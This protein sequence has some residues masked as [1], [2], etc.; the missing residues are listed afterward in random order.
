MITESNSWLYGDLSKR[1]KSYINLYIL[2]YVKHAH[3][4][5]FCSSGTTVTK[6][7][8]NH[9]WRIKFYSACF[10]TPLYLKYI[11]QFVLPCS[12]L[13]GTGGQVS[14]RGTSVPN[15]AH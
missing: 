10:C 14:L 3:I 13:A 12:V 7:A 15:E 2:A 8:A 9:L 6:T 11:W 4:N 1:N 5:N